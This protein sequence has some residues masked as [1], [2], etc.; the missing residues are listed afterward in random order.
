LDHGEAAVGPAAAPYVEIAVGV[1]ADQQ[2]G[3]WVAHGTQKGDLPGMPASNKVFSYPCVSV[4]ECSD[5]KMKHNVNYWDNATF[6]LQIGF[7][8]APAKAVNEP[9]C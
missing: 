2:P 3:K 8:S 5:G 1:D 9:R 6:M 7:L 4:M